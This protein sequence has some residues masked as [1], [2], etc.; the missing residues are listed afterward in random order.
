MTS[1]QWSDSY[2]VDN[3]DIDEQH[4]Q[5]IYICNSMQTTLQFGTP[6]EVSGAG[7]QALMKMIDYAK[8][9]FRQEEDYMRS[10][11]YP[12]FV[13]HH[14]LHENFEYLVYQ[15]NRNVNE[16]S[17]LVLNEKILLLIQ[18]WLINHILVE[19]KRYAD[20]ARGV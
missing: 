4:K 9:H 7:H 12:D 17:E 6:D 2:S 5:W 15:F 8:Y 20:F 11:G 13:R 10:I 1:I 19:D 14:R 3:Q 16:S 18:R